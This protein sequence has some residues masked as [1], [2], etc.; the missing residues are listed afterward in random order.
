VLL[1]ADADGPNWTDK[2]IAEA[3][4]CRTKTVEN[5]RQRLVTR[6]FDIALNGKKHETPPRSKYQIHVHECPTCRQA[7]VA[8]PRGELALS[9][10]E[11]ATAH[12]D[13]R[14]HRPGQRATATIPP[15]TRREVLA[16]DRHRCR[17]KGCTHTRH[18]H[19]HH[20]VPR[21]AGGGNETGN[22][23]T[24]CA[25]CH[26]LWHERGGELREL[27]RS[28]GSA[29]EQPEFVRS[30]GSAA[31]QRVP[32]YDQEYAQQEGRDDQRKAQARE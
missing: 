24:L 4:S 12:C 13:A 22:L 21:A 16:R 2:K 1:K 6:G 14:I 29:A 10:I 27:L 15:K 26:R 18:L 31:E 11:A 17:R 28:T 9:E 23:V 19:L 20:L 30:T 3:F 8:T 7:A 32:E 25:A 5:I